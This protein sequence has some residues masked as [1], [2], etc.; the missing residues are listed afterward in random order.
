M[1]TFKTESG[2]LALVQNRKK[3]AKKYVEAIIS[4]SYSSQYALAVMC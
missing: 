2:D 3:E 4:L 1:Q